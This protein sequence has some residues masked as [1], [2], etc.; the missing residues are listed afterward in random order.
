MK[1]MSH[2]HRRAALKSAAVRGPELKPYVILDAS[3]R[4]DLR[5]E[6]GGVKVKKLPNGKQVVHL[7]DKTARF[8]LDS[9]SIAPMDNNT[10]G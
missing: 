7:T 6:F 1:N 4:P 10:N 2:R 8:Y 3:H 9:G 5:G